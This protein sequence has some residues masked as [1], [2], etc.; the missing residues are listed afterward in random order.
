MHD[1]SQRKAVENRPQVPTNITREYF[2]YH[3]DTIN[4]LQ[5]ETMTVKLSR[6]ESITT[7]GTRLSVELNLMYHSSSF[8]EWGAL[9]ELID[10][11][12]WWEIHRSWHVLRKI[13]KHY[14]LELVITVKRIYLH[15]LFPWFMLR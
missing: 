10:E 8:N 1:D 5:I 9:P 6:K 3:S 12:A 14:S 11:L 7:K 13:W 4:K 15:S 2:W